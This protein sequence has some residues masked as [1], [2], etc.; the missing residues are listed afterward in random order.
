MELRARLAPRPTTSTPHSSFV[1]GMGGFVVPSCPL[2]LADPSPV[3]GWPSALL[4][5][6]EQSDAQIGV[7]GCAAGHPPRRGP[8]WTALGSTGRGAGQGHGGGL[9]GL[10]GSS[11]ASNADPATAEWRAVG[12]ATHASAPKIDKNISTLD[13]FL[14][15]VHTTSQKKVCQ[16]PSPL[17]VRRPPAR[18]Y[19]K[20]GPDPTT[21]LVSGFLAHVVAS[22]CLFPALL[23][24][25]A[26][27]PRRSHSCPRAQQKAHTSPPARC[28]QR[29]SNTPHPL[30]GPLS[31]RPRT[32]RRHKQ[33]WPSCPSGSVPPNIT[34]PVPDRLNP[35]S[36]GDPLSDTRTP[37]NSHSSLSV[38]STPD[39]PLAA[40]SIRPL[41]VQ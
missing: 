13:F 24:Q 17:P 1:S 21:C 30:V 40:S 14:H 27:A 11:F 3:N 10:S 33:G 12:G 34:H 4:H 38:S 2:F 16:S 9:E 23:A 22:L 28:Q 37:G 20:V 41:P 18:D 35:S 6:A 7:T 25:S 39:P 32:D 26:P 31:R 15:A 19:A 29:L 5:R 8:P 36:V